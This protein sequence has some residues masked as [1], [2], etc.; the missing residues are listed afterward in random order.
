[1]RQLILTLGCVGLLAASPIHAEDL[2]AESIEGYIK[3]RDKVM[4]AASANMGGIAKL[5]SG[6]VNLPGRMAGHAQ[7]LENL[8][9]DIPALFPEGSDFGETDAK[10]EVWSDSKKFSL[11]A[12]TAQGKAKML[13]EA[14]TGGDKK[15]IAAAFKDLGGSCKACH[16]KF[17]AKH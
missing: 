1:M 16:K 2:S 5:L 10:A 9:T 13:N 3:Y 7:A 14:V 12:E 17:K 8:M 15:A 4:D 6:H 11:A